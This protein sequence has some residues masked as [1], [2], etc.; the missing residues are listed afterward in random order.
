MITITLRGLMYLNLDHDHSQTVDVPEPWQ[1]LLVDHHP[2]L[3][4]S[5][6]L[7]QVP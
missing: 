7:P 5:P 3:A 2:H 1:E 4:E 6:R